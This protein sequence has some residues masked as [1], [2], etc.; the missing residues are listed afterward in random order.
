M[1]VI[2]KSFYIK[3]FET[4]EVKFIFT[5]YNNTVFQRE[6]RTDALKINIFYVRTGV[7]F[8]VPFLEST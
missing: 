1:W 4:S 6:K 8:L 7:S 2:K 5:V 3:Y